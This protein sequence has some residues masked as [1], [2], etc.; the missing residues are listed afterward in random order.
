MRRG[1]S[2]STCQSLSHRCFLQFL[3]EFPVA[4]SGVWVL[5]PPRHA[6]HESAVSS[7]SAHGLRWTAS[8]CRALNHSDSR[9]RTGGFHASLT[10]RVTFR[11]RLASRFGRRRVRC[12]HGCEGAAA[13]GRCTIGPA[14][15][16]ASMSVTVGVTAPR[17]PLLMILRLRALSLPREL[18]I[19]AGKPVSKAA[20]AGSDRRRSTW[21]VWKRAMTF[22]ES[23][24]VQAQRGIP[25]TT[26]NIYSTT[27]VDPILIGPHLGV[28]T[29]ANH[30]MWYGAGGLAVGEVDGS[31]TA[32]DGVGGIST[33]NPGSKWSAGW[34]LG[35]GIEHMVDR[36]W[37]VKVEYDYVRLGG[38]GSTAYYVGT[39]ASNQCDL[40][41]RSRTA[42]WQR[43]DRRPRFR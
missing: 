34:F 18:I 31:A 4:Y 24:R 36:N 35:A 16:V 20:I 21:P 7:P 29:D 8:G 2:S 17:P 3:R 43:H 38:G 1:C 26:T 11:C 42:P 5:L 30:T 39:N 19:V 28:L 27:N 9:N 33:A 32:N 41:R 13:G 25:G 12:R 15:T 23:D 40:S 22:R 6:T 10:D 37:S 14:G